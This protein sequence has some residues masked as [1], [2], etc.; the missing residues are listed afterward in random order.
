MLCLAKVTL[1]LLRTS[2]GQQSFSSAVRSRLAYTDSENIVRSLCT[3]KKEKKVWDSFKIN[4]IGTK[5][6][7]ILNAAISLPQSGL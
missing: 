6:S 2:G 4:R 5:L 1:P 7:A 3:I